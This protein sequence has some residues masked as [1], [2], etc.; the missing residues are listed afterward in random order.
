MEIMKN[1]NDFNE[2]LE[3]S[4]RYPVVI[5]KHSASCPFSAMSQMEVASSKHDIDIFSIVVQYVPELSKE[6][7]KKLDVEHASPQA[8]IIYEGKAVSHHYRSEIKEMKL[9]R[10]VQEAASKS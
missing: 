10:L 1:S 4:Y 5:Y 8:I 2:A 6:I 7:S 9:R 3:A